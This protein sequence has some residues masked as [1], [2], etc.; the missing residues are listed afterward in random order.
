MSYETIKHLKDT[1]FKRLSGVQRET[2]ERMLAVVEKG[3]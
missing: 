3:L 1:D 2:I